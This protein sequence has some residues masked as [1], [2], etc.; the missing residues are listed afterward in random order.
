MRI[1]IVILVEELFGSSFF[2]GRH[3]FYF[4]DGLNDLATRVNDYD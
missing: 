1:P 3:W 4:I 2:T